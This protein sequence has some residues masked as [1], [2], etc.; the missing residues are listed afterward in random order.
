MMKRTILRR[1]SAL[2]AAAMLLPYAGGLTALAEEFA[3]PETALTGQQVSAEQP[4][5]ELPTEATEP[6]E[7]SAAQAGEGS[8]LS[9]W[10]EA[11][12]MLADAGLLPEQVECVPENPDAPVV[13]MEDM[14]TL[15]QKI[16]EVM[17]QETGVD[18]DTLT[19]FVQQADAQS[20]A[21]YALRAAGGSLSAE[22]A[23]AQLPLTLMANDWTR[24]QVLSPSAA[25]GSSA[26]SAEGTVM[27]VDDNCMVVQVLDDTGRPLDGALVTVKRKTDGTTSSYTTQT[28]PGTGTA[29]IAVIPGIDDTMY[30]I[31]DVQAVGY[32]TQTHLDLKLEG[33]SQVTF[34]LQKLN[35]NEPFYIRTADLSGADLVRSDI[36]I[37]LVPK[38]EDSAIST[39]TV[40]LARNPGSDAAWPEGDSALVLMAKGDKEKSGSPLGDDKLR[41]VSRAGKELEPAGSSESALYGD[42]R[43]YTQTGR[44]NQRAINL[45]RG[46]DELSLRYGENSGTILADLKRVTVRNAFVNRPV[47]VRFPFTIGNAKGSGSSSSSG[48]SIKNTDTFLDGTSVNLDMPTV[49]CTV[50]MLPSG[51]YFMGVTLGTK[52]GGDALNKAESFVEK[53]VNPAQ[54][55]KAEGFWKEMCQNW[56]DSIQKL[57]AAS[58]RIEDAESSGYFGATSGFSCTLYGMIG[59]MGGYNYDTGRLEGSLSGALKL[60]GK[61][62][63][64]FYWLIGPVPVHLGYELSAGGGLDGSVG[65]YTKVPAG[66]ENTDGFEYI[67][68]Q[69]AIL[70]AA[71]EHSSLGSL[72]M[73]IDLGVGLYAGV[74]VKGV[75]AVQAEGN[76]GLGLVNTFYATDDNPAHTYP[77]Q[78]LTLTLTGGFRV[79]ILL[80]SASKI[81]KYSK[82]LLDSWDK[83]RAAYALNAL[84]L[85]ESGTVSLNLDAVSEG[86]AGNASYTAS[87]ASG[88][89]ASNVS[90]ADTVASNVL[91]DNDLRIVRTPNAA[92]VFRLASVDG[93]PRLVWQSM[94]P[95]YGTV[96]STVHVL[97]TQDVFN[98][99]AIANT[100]QNTDPSNRDNVYLTLITGDVSQG[101]TIEQRAATTGV[102]GI[103]LNLKTGEVLFDKQVREPDGTYCHSPQAA[104]VGSTCTPMWI[105]SK[106]FT[107]KANTGR[108]YRW[109]DEDTGAFPIGNIKNSM[110][111]TGLVGEGLPCLLRVDWSGSSLRLRAYDSNGKGVQGMECTL[112]IDTGNI[113]EAE[114]E[115]LLEHLYVSDDNVYL[116]SVGRLVR[117][118]M[119]LTGRDT[120][121]TATTA[122][123][124]DGTELHIPSGQ[125]GYDLSVLPGSSNCSGNLI[126]VVQRA[127]EN[128][129]PVNVVKNQYF[130]DLSKMPFTVHPAQ[131]YTLPDTTSVGTFAVLTHPAGNG[132]DGLTLVYNAN[133]REDSSG[134]VHSCDVRQWTKG[135][136]RELNADEVYLPMAVVKRGQSDIALQV[137]V[138]NNGGQTE[139]LV[140]LK[141]WDEHGDVIHLNN[142]ST[143]YGTVAY[144]LSP[145]LA[146]GES[147]WITL[148]TF[149]AL[150]CWQGGFHT[151]NVKASYNEQFSG[152]RIAA[153]ES[154]GSAAIQ[155]DQSLLTLSGELST[156]GEKILVNLKITN[157]S[158]VEVP[159]ESLKLMQVAYDGDSEADP[160]E[161]AT[162]ALDFSALSGVSLTDGRTNANG[163]WREH[164]YTTMLDVTEAM[165]GHRY[166]LLY[167]T[168]NN[169]A[170]GVNAYSTLLLE[171]P[172]LDPAYQHIGTDVDRL[173]TGTTA[174]DK[175]LTQWAAT[176][177]IA[178]P[179]A[180]FRFAGWKDESGTIVSTD[181]PFHFQTTDCAEDHRVFTAVFEDAGSHLLTLTAAPAAGTVQVEGA[182]NTQNVSRGLVCTATD[183]TALTLSA[184][185]AAGKRFTGWYEN[186]VLVSADAPLTLTLS[187]SRSL[188]AAFEDVPVSGG[189][190]SRVTVQSGLQQ[191]DLPVDMTLSEAETTLQTALASRMQPTGSALYSARMQLRLNNGQWL[192]VDGDPAQPVTITLTLPEGVNARQ[193]TVTVAHL[194][195]RDSQDGSAGS[196]EFPAV[197]VLSE[198][199]VQVTVSSL[200]SFAVGWTGT[201]QPAT[202]KP[203][204]PQSDHPEIGEAIRN[205]T[206]GVDD[207]PAKPAQADASASPAGSTPPPSAANRN[208]SAAL[209][210]NTG[211]SAGTGTAPEPTP[212]PDDSSTPPPSSDNSGTAGTENK[213]DTVTEPT[214]SAEPSAEPT[215]EPEP[216]EPGKNS[217]PLPW[218]LVPLALLGAGAVWILKRRL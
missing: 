173:L 32:Q 132:L 22:E 125:G 115:N 191:D 18:A 126:T 123:N 212:L 119:D 77:H 204:E 165:K 114:R 109:N 9:E 112:P 133:V 193:Q 116:V 50:M 203:A 159:C 61:F 164:G 93:K 95:E 74:G 211:S 73:S 196:V 158:M 184:T 139:D 214:A 40:M 79:T 98:Y 121:L 54:Q 69:L 217:I 208:A 157:E 141:A 148:S 149:T 59:I 155:M 5:A 202:P 206:W 52:L 215:S 86:T 84:P 117:V 178:T 25:D 104:G 13:G 128:G 43:I 154:Q 89:L 167:L 8:A 153:E 170:S 161:V 137:K 24:V 36:S 46:G 110:R 17:Q 76:G 172:D 29:G 209:S 122:K 138:T 16:V 42:T 102:R 189:T 198:R 88:P 171:N 201:S 55:A 85:G 188:T 47:K 68:N 3:T 78:K 146:P 100:A 160:D 33:K 26:A 31:A 145:A 67:F 181:N 163:S 60:S 96:S 97:D 7:E 80:V 82:V 53:P 144:G 23:Q 127:D 118:A 108:L 39:L 65:V 44:W 177:L 56:N 62:S 83:S 192:T 216:A 136:G 38:E 58:A 20:Q 12:Q 11:A 124:T 37:D 194:R 156:D 87:T 147:Q 35:E 179:A 182:D 185:P 75:A 176:D 10:T 135:L 120:S 103:T 175:G 200:S 28:V 151:I 162:V 131:E 6:A 129:N 51:V 63:Q 218:I 152:S 168:T 41:V 134:A 2:L 199:E 34:Q 197:T 45:L 106:N 130:Y 66:Y 57:R 210:G 169:N 90:G 205:G 72:G 111:S 4:S 213:P 166:L 27:V 81:W 180:G 64:T 71:S 174:G 183:G 107:G 48:F 30:C 91:S 101:D 195:T 150:D 21:V 1:V 15:M 187:A 92:A 190:E 49:P 19:A 140:W 14:D 113:S 143:K 94:D 105:E 207:E 70:T 142:E 99:T 186:G